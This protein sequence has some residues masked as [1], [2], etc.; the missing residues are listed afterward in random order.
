MHIRAMFQPN[1]PHVGGRVTLFI[2]ILGAVS[3]SE[4]EDA[5]WTVW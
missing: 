1:D 3:E 4:G 5:E 2:T